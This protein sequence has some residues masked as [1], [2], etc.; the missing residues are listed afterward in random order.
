MDQAPNQSAV[1]AADRST[2]GRRSR[3]GAVPTWL[4][5]ALLGAVVVIVPVAVYVF[6]Y[7][8][9]RVENATIRNFRALDAAAG[10]VAS[11]LDNLPNVVSNHSFGVSCAMLKVVHERI[12]GIPDETRP[13]HDCAM[14]RKRE[15]NKVIANEDEFLAALSTWDRHLSHLRTRYGNPNQSTA[16]LKEELTYEIVEFVLTSVP[17]EKG[18]EPWREL[19][20]LLEHYRRGYN[21]AEAAT[22]TLVTVD[23]LP[24]NPTIEHLEFLAKRCSSKKCSLHSESFSNLLE[25]TGQN[26]CGQ[27]TRF[28]ESGDGMVA[29]FTDC[30]PFR[31]RSPLLYEAL[32]QHLNI[33][34]DGDV[35]P[36]FLALDLFGARS[37]AELA[38]MLTQAS[39]HLA[40]FFDHYLIANGNGQILVE[41]ETANDLV[42]GTEAHR[43]AARA[44]SNHVDISDLLSQSR[45]PDDPFL[46]LGA[47]RQPVASTPG[48]HSV[49]KSLT[50]GGVDLRVFIHPFIVNNIESSGA[51]NTTREHATSDRVLYMV[52]VVGADDLRSEAIRLRLAWVVMATLAVLTVLTLFPT[53]RFGTAG[54][55]LMLRPATLTAI[56]VIPVVGVV[57]YVVLALGIVTN[58]VDE[59]ALDHAVE[60]IAGQMKRSFNMELD[61]RIHHLHEFARKYGQPPD[62]GTTS[63]PDRDLKHH[64]YC[65]AAPDG[66]SG[67]NAGPTASV[68]FPGYDFASL[69]D[70]QGR[71]RYCDNKRNFRSPKLDLQFR[72]YFKRPR[73]G[74]LWRSDDTDDTDRI[75]YFMERI[76]SIVQGEV[77]TVVAICS[78]PPDPDDT[79]DSSDPPDPDDTDDGCGVASAGIRFESLARTVPPHFGFAVIDRTD[80]RT[81]FHSDERR[82]MATNF[83]QDVGADSRLLSQLHAGADGTIGLVYDGIPIRARVTALRE[84][85]PWTLIVYRDHEIEDQLLLVTSSLALFCTFLAAVLVALFVGLSVITYRLRTP[86]RTTF[87]TLFTHVLHAG[88]AARTGVAATAGVAASVAILSHWFFP[89]WAVVPFV[90]GVSFAAAP[91]LLGW[92]MFRSNTEEQ[93]VDPAKINPAVVFVVVGLAIIPTSTWFLYHRAQLSTGLKYY[94]AKRIDESTELKQESYRRMAR[95]YKQIR[96]RAAIWKE[97]AFWISDASTYGWK[98]SPISAETEPGGWTFDLLRPLVAPSTLANNLMVH[99]TVADPSGGVWSPRAV[100]EAILESADNRTALADDPRR[101]P[102]SSDAAWHQGWWLIRTLLVAA[103]LLLGL[104]LLAFVIAWSVHAAVWGRPRCIATTKMLQAGRDDEGTSAQASAPHEPLRIMALYRNSRKRKG[105]EDKFRNRFAE[106][107]RAKWS[108]QNITWEPH[109][110]EPSAVSGNADSKILH[111]VDDLES[112]LTDEKRNLALLDELEK[113]GAERAPVLIWTRVV[114]GYRLS[115]RAGRTVGRSFDEDRFARWSRLL[116][117]FRMQIVCETEDETKKE[118]EKQLDN[119]EGYCQEVVS[120][121]EEEALANPELWD[122]AA[123]VVEEASTPHGERSSQERRSDHKQREFAMGQFRARAEGYFNMLWAQS[124]F[125]ERLQLH[126]LAYGGLANREQTAVLSSLAS[127]GLVNLDGIVRLR[128]EA[129]GE[130][131][132]HDLT[133][134]ELVAW[135]KKGQGNAW[136]AIWPPLAIGAAL[137]LV[138]FFQTNPEMLSAMLAIMAAILPFTLSLLR[139]SP[140]V[141]QSSSE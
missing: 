86:S 115:D 136:K 67:T 15:G 122:L 59:R 34:E 17:S 16:R 37:V 35:H 23:P 97:H 18:L 131:I 10:R 138:F 91:I 107:R 125:D 104:L 69:I 24:L 108:G 123:G 84:E 90:A 114:P 58:R 81:L 121:M 6:F 88:S 11:V 68:E 56:A 83:I 64:F 50:V 28:V 47:D 100:F 116:G 93:A 7:Q 29:E 72:E 2:R 57:F 39:G 82:A 128:S 75:P 54:P 78:D 36:V 102:H 71:P 30:R 26:R 106:I 41:L 22:T 55:R 130:F 73:D 132:V 32:R 60:D 127:R 76:D 92:K 98:P 48:R 51:G 25:R 45:P 110:W 124:T 65:K 1:S 85:M 62:N 113:I 89:L 137:A 94:V 117:G 105:I 118:F 19:R 109:E 74:Q 77:A 95:D 139:G 111:V 38:P 43:T 66:S 46:S 9:G 129:F 20:S 21:R 14:N 63:G 79:D 42:A 99:R 13:A 52:G 27:P 4:R 53:L 133:H 101:A 103:M 87:S 61:D 120:A 40:R 3:R 5:I 49:L 135:Q 119:T 12:T 70:E 8:A 134:N 33:E 96:S 44:F 31:T 140:N 80:G 112:V 141:G 126:T